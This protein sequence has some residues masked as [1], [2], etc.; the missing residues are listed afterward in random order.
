ML[1]SLSIMVTKC[2]E[3]AGQFLE[4]EGFPERAG[5]RFCGYLL[6]TPWQTYGEDRAHSS[7]FSAEG[8]PEFVV[9]VCAAFGSSITVRPVPGVSTQTETKQEGLW[10][11]QL[12]LTHAVLQPCPAVLLAGCFMLLPQRS[13]RSH[14]SHK[15][16]LQSLQCWI[17]E[18]IHL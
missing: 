4:K 8:D 14:L 16:Q 1:Q 18:G 17:S 13:L 12:S 15:Q 5:R 3:I 6:W 7:G 2:S 10:F 11:L 9:G